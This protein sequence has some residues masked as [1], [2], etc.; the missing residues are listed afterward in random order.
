MFELEKDERIRGIE[1]METALAMCFA[2]DFILEVMLTREMLD[3]EPAEAARLSRTL[4]ERWSRRY[5]AALTNATETNG[6]TVRQSYATK[7]F[8]D[9][10]ARKALQ[11]SSD[12][13]R[14]LSTNPPPV[15]TVEITAEM[16]QAGAA[17]L[18]EVRNLPPEEVAATVYRAMVALSR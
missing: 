6:E 15:Q 16:K 11:R 4:V 10:L 14:S 12:M 9:R 7:A 5:G 2:H 3:L 18:S 1:P 17:A 8:V 13:R